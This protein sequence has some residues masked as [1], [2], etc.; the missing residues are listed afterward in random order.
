MSNS[1]DIR[2]ENYENKISSIVN[3]NEIK[4][5]IIFY[6]KTKPFDVNYCKTNIMMD[7]IKNN[8]YIELKY[9]KEDHLRCLFKNIKLNSDIIKFLIDKEIDINFLSKNESLTCSLVKEFINH[10]NMNEILCNSKLSIAELNSIIDINTIKIDFNKLNKIRHIFIEKEK[11]MDLIKNI[12]NVKNLM[13]KFKNLDNKFNDFNVLLEENTKNILT[14]KQE[15]KYLDTYVSLYLENLDERKNNLYNEFNKKIEDLNLIND[16]LFI[17]KENI[18]NIQND[19]YEQ[20]NKNNK[21]IKDK[22][23]TI[24]NNLKYNNA[25]LN[26]ELKKNFNYILYLICFNILQF[27][28]LIFIIYSLYQN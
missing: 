12:D 24:I 18:T 1:Y 6:D 25:N 21:K 26:Y 11:E 20:I 8:Y 14:V 22:M 15:L 3:D 23:T 16:E 7:I 5:K 10:W 13:N 4:H 19:L 28:I 17:I 2:W 9:W 27:S